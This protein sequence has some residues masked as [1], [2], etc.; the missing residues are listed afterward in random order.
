MEKAT[1]TESKLQEIVSKA[2][3]PMIENEFKTKLDNFADEIKT[4]IETEMKKMAQRIEIHDR[5]EDDLKGGFKSLGHFCYDVY[6][7]DTSNNRYVSK[8]M[9]D[10]LAKAAGASQSEGDVNYG[11]A[12]VPVQFRNELMTMVEETNE[13]L[14][15][16]TIVPMETNIIEMP[17]LYSFD[18]SSGYVHGAIKW[19]W[20]DEDTQLTESRFKTA[21]FQLKLH[22]LTGLCYVT[23]RLMQDSPRSI[24]ALIRTGFNDGL[25][26]QYNNVLIRG[27]GA[28]QPLGC[29]NAN[30]L[31]TVA[32]ETGQSAATIYYEN[33][34]KMYQSAYN[35]GRC[36]WVANPNI[37]VQ[38]A[39]MS[40]AVGTGGAPVYLPANGASG[41]PYNTLMGLPLIWNDHC[42]TLGT[43]GD[44]ILVDWSQYM[45]GRPAGDDGV[46]FDTSIHIKFDYLQTAFRFYLRM[47]GAHTWPTYFTPP[48]ATTS[49]RSP[50]VA[51][52]TRS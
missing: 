23:E 46:K 14:P 15:R 7:M 1:L 18:Q 5:S 39:T 35:V 9:S 11:G 30:C 28:G 27:T 40:L 10:W 26:F 38:L 31:V 48:Q 3:A 33:I 41:R 22:D 42:S 13:L 32:K 19:Y 24:E 51:L 6:K 43:V 8:E 16:C 25:N 34:L 36:V 50:V 45:V 17:Y 52:E 29:L 2:A 49:Y 44:I 21:K 20:V 12:L 4:Q 37:L 47:A